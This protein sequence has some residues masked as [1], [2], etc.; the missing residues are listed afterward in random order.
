MMMNGDESTVYIISGTLYNYLSTPIY[1]MCIL[2]EIPDLAQENLD[3]ITVTG[4]VTTALTAFRQETEDAGGE[5]DGQC[6]RRSPGS[7]HHLDR[8]GRHR[9]HGK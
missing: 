9:R 7:H 3:S 6:C 8:R 4:A 5:E 1:D 2:P